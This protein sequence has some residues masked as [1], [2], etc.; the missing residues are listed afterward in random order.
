MQTRARRALQGLLAAVL[1]MNAPKQTQGVRGSPGHT[2][3]PVAAPSVQDGPHVR[4][5]LLLDTPEAPPGRAHT[6][7]QAPDTVQPKCVANCK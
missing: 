4:H 7:H 1:V 6:D 5:V 3:G 2:L